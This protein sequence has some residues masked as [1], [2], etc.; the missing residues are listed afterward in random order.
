MTIREALVHD[1]EQMQVIRNAVKENILTNR[2]LVKYEDYVT[3]L[4]QRGKG[5]ICETDNLITGFAIAD[6]QCNNIW[7]LFVR[8]G[9]EGRGIGRQLHDTMLNWYFSQTQ[10]A[11][12]LSTAFHTRAAAFYEKA[13]WV[14]T[15]V[16][17]KNEARFEMTYSNWISIQDEN[18]NASKQ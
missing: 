8:Q 5:W 7:A 9:F 1:I 16:H 17:G 2:E 18:L 6:L 15:G 3:Y 13:G 10:Q 11:V 14:Y 12:W 4:F